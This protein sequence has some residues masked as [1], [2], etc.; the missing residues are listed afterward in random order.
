MCIGMKETK[1]GG[2]KGR[3][4]MSTAEPLLARFE[5]LTPAMLLALAEAMEPARVATWL[6][7]EEEEEEED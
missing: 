3:K 7:E 1:S 6:D 4:A 2:R 5:P